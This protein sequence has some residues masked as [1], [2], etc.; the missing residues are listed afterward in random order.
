MKRVFSLKAFYI[1]P[2]CF[3]AFICFCCE[4]NKL[5][6]TK[7][8]FHVHHAYGHKVFLQTIPYVD[9]NPVVVDSATIKSGNDTIVLYIPQ[10]NE[11]PYRLRINDS[12]IEILI[13]NDSPVITV[14]ANIFKP[15][16]YTV[17][18]SKA[19]QSVKSFLDSQ[20]K[21]SFKGKSDATKIDS[22]KLKNAPKQS[23]DSLTKEY[24]RG[25][26]DFFQQYINYADTVSSPATFLFIYN[27]VDFGNDYKGLKIFIS[28]AAKRFPEN[29]EIQKLK[30]RTLEY[31]RIYE[32]EY[33]IGDHLPELILPDKNGKNFSTY[34]V[35]GK[36]VFMDFW[37]TWCTGCLKYDQVK[38]IAKTNFPS[39]RFEIVSIALDSEKDAWRHYIEAHKFTWVQLMD[40][41]MWRGPTLKAY[42]IDSIPFNFLLA[43]D[44]KS[45]S[46]A[47]KPD[48]VISVLSKL[49]K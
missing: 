49:I 8:V 4:Q 23:I 31:L 1:L 42:S 43:P 48:S 45:L 20:L 37:S 5:S 10:G 16:E 32:V 21:L 19:T 24:D 36:Y 12:R 25:I 28:K 13:I 14:E 11:T 47:I 33:N 44:G 29:S 2:F 27:N 30:Q 35:K 9:E 39:D 6:K 34:S 22:L 38:V 3:L 18:N 41:K 46:K 26:A 17:G 15:F 7:V 40:E